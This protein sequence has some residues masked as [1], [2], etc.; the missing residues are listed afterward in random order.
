MTRLTA[1]EFLIGA[2]AIGYFA[3]V[4]PVPAVAQSIDETASV[5]AGCHGD[6]GVPIDKT[7]PNIWGQ[8]RLYLLN[9]LN[10]FKVG[11]RTNEQMAPIVES[12]SKT[13][14]EALATQ[15]GA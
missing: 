9:Q 6:K 8:N 14:I 1:S 2:L 10:D 11:H 13:D 3:I 12:L 4:Q 7:I 5:C 15:L